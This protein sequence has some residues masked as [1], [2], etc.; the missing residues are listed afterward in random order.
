[1]GDWED[2]HLHDPADFAD[3]YVLLD[4]GE[5]L[6]TFSRAEPDEKPPEGHRPHRT[7]GAAVEG[8]TVTLRPLT[9]DR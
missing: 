3:A 4:D 6:V 5:A 7:P 2:E 1:M 8:H 9:E